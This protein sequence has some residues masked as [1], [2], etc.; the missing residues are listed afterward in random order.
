MEEKELK[1][2]R[3]TNTFCDFYSRK[4]VQVNLDKLLKVS[5]RYKKW[6]I[7]L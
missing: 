1:N 5:R 4:F 2:T 7:K 3:K 6:I